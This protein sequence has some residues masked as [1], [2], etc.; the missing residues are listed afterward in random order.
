MSMIRPG[1][2]LMYDMGDFDVSDTYLFVLEEIEPDLVFAFDLIDPDD[3]EGPGEIPEDNRI[4]VRAAALEQAPHLIS[5]SQGGAW[6]HR[7]GAE[8]S[9]GNIEGAVDDL[10]PPF[11]LTRSAYARLAAGDEVSMPTLWGPPAVK[12]R[13]SGKERA[14]IE[15]EGEAREVEALRVKDEEGSLVLLVLADTTWPLVLSHEEAGADNF[16]RLRR[17]D[18]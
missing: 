8:P 18:S 11:L 2:R 14:S 5:L 4:T 15:V 1:S 13:A 6:A 12:V 16:W 7:P 3:E 9:F 10:R 17:I